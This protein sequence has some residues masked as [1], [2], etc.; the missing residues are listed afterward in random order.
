MAFAGRRRCRGGRTAVRRGMRAGRAE[1]DWP[2][3]RIRGGRFFFRVP[4]LLDGAPELHEL[5]L[6]ARRGGVVLGAEGHVRALAH[7]VQDP[8]R[9]PQSPAHDQPPRR[10]GQDVD[11][12]HHRRRRDGGRGDH[13]PPVV[14]SGVSQRVVGDARKEHPETQHELVRH[15]Q[16]AS[17]FRR[18]H[19]RDV[20]GHAHRGRAH[21]EPHDEA[22]QRQADG[23]RGDGHRERAEEEKHARHRD[24][25]LPAHVRHQRAAYERPEHRAELGHADDRLRGRGRQVQV[26]VGVHVQKR[27]RDEPQ[28]VPEQEPAQAGERGD[29]QQGRHGGQ[30]APG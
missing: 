2:R 24:R 19:L 7:A 12:E 25:P 4:L 29:A 5:R 11:P 1:A 23:V 26:L 22:A 13:P 6:D 15:D 20:R 3:I 16:R 30:P 21:A 14:F 17:V 9:V 10:L 27:A 28:V 8:Q 18:G